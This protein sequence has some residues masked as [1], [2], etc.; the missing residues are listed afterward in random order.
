MEKVW[1]KQIKTEIEER[2]NMEKKL[3]LIFD[4]NKYVEEKVVRNIWRRQN[5]VRTASEQYSHQTVVNR[6]LNQSMDMLWTYNT[7]KKYMKDGWKAQEIIY[8]IKMEKSMRARSHN[9]T[10]GLDWDENERDPSLPHY[11]QRI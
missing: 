9:R 11:M 4:W 2:E 8:T 5:E 7:V 1:V 3:K 6:K 10:M